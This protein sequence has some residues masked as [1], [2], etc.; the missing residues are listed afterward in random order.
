MISVGMIP[1]GEIGLIVGAI[2]ISL[3]VLSQEALG[4]ILLMCLL[5]TGTG[6]FLFRAAS[7]V[8]RNE[9][10]HGTDE[11]LPGAPEE[12]PTP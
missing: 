1:R 8:A 5:T 4:A 3:G 10:V 6:G 9:Y 12:R 7:R 2:G 11:G